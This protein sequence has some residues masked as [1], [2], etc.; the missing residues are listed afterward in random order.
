MMLSKNKL[1]IDI[2]HDKLQCIHDPRFQ[3]EKSLCFFLNPHYDDIIIRKKY[4]HMKRLCTHKNHQ[5]QMLV[6]LVPNFFHKCQCSKCFFV[7]HKSHTLNC[8]QFCHLHEVIMHFIQHSP[9]FEWERH[10]P[11]NVGWMLNEMYNEMG[12]CFVVVWAHNNA[13]EENF[14]QSLDKKFKSMGSPIVHYTLNYI[15][16]LE[17]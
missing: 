2:V 3:A 14:F 4:H 8:S 5:I 15:V 13:L 7:F 6:K 12:T 11:L 17:K 16:N 10:V 1:C 9:N